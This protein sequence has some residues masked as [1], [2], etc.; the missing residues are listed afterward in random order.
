[1]AEFTLTCC[2]TADMSRKYFEE[3][4]I[5]YVCFHFN[6]DGVEYPDDMGLSM[7][8][9]EFYKRIENG[10]APTTSQVN[11]DQYE[12]LF[13]P[14]LES[15]RDILH[16]T[17]SSGISGTYN[18]CMIAANELREKFP[19]RKLIVIDSL[20]A[21]SGYG[22]LIDYAADLRDSGMGAEEVAAK[23]EE[24]KLY[25]HH[26][27]FSTDLTSYY[28]GGRIS[29]TS[30]VMGNLLNICPLLNVNDE[31]KLIPRQKYRGKKKVIEEMVKRMEEHAQNSLDYSGKCFIS[32]SACYDD[33]KKVAALI[34]QKFPKLNGSVVINDI[35]T[36]IGSHTGPGTVA[37]FFWGDKREQ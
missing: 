1:M 35:G 24:A 14:I 25:V 2:S 31:G 23:L 15:G 28:R 9:D 33:A 22:L 10:A 37:L 20:A 11:V 21:S 32:Q 30:M 26:W 6:M 5:S 29:K 4:D 16:L 19:D 27:F 34:E 18:S 3:R 7:P 36:V 13:T 8:I 12:A 17:L